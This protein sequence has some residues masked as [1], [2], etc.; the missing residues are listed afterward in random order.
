MDTE[1]TIKKLERLVSL[2]VNMWY[3]I[4]SFLDVAT[5]VSCLYVSKTWYKCA[6]EPLSW[7]SKVKMRIEKI[8]VM[9][10]D[11][12]KFSIGPMGAIVYSTFK[13]K[14][15][16]CS[17]NGIFNHLTRDIDIRAYYSLFM[18]Q[19]KSDPLIYQIFSEIQSKCFQLQTLHIDNSL[20]QLDNQ[21][22][23]QLSRLTTLT[24]IDIPLRHS[25][26]SW[27]DLYL[28]DYAPMCQLINLQHMGYFKYML[29]P[30]NMEVCKIMPLV[31]LDCVS[32][33]SA[34]YRDSKHQDRKQL[35][36][37]PDCQLSQLICLKEAYST[38]NSLTI[39]DFYLNNVS[40]L[41]PFEHLQTLCLHAVNMSSSTFQHICQITGRRLR[42]MNL[43]FCVLE[44]WNYQGLE[45]CTSL[46][47]LDICAMGMNSL[48]FPRLAQLVQLR[49][50][51]LT[52]CN[53][54]DDS[55][56]PTLLSLNHLTDLDL[57]DTRISPHG[58]MTLATT[59]S[60]LEKLNAREQNIT[61][62]LVLRIHERR[63]QHNFP[64]LTIFYKFLEM[65]EVD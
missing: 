6:I 39:N 34:H 2:P 60:R 42:E 36:S 20:L 50:L 16:D 23:R 8:N 52:R 12:S 43:L 57:S 46:I 35:I 64:P 22:I 58:V 32:T 61:D 44:D 26:N 28:L 17:R 48:T 33:T 25:V 30:W 62:D 27:I 5:H 45:M 54:V 21:I 65:E 38:L 63:G 49:I 10:S 13:P 55:I 59:L 7:T 3:C 41:Q 18:D 19:E 14:Q 53:A 31:E 15:F 37:L 47:H 4:M 24:S 9:S 56:C 51:S 11:E 29:I 1:K 40:F